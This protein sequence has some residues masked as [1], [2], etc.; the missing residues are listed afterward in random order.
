MYFYPARIRN[1]VAI[2]SVSML[3][4]HENI[5][6]SLTTASQDSRRVLW[7]GVYLLGTSHLV[8]IP[9]WKLYWKSPLKGFADESRWCLCCSSRSGTLNYYHFDTELLY[10]H[11]L[12]AFSLY[13]QWDMS[14]NF[15]FDDRLCTTLIEFTY[16][17]SFRSSKNIIVRNLVRVLS[18]VERLFQ[19]RIVDQILL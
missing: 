13:E 6:Q 10:V 12:F 11:L 17:L 5:G 16:R 8:P 4:L 2:A 1:T 3:E 15:A 7:L 9:W 18:N 14:I 19:G